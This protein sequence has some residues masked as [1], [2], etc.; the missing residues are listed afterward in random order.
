MK[1][2]KRCGESKAF[3]CFSPRKDAKDGL[4]YWCNQC[5]TAATTA[6]PRR[7]AV[8]DAYR[9]RNRVECLI[10]TKQCIHRDRVDTPMDELDVFVLEEALRLTHMRSGEW[11]IDHIKAVSKGGT[12]RFDNIQVVPKVWNRAKGTETAR[13]FHV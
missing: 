8:V 12:N 7:K 3:D 2:C 6:G 10:R 5:K 11:E 13:F 1:T 4:A 9:D